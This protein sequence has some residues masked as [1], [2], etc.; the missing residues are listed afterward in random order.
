LIHR[1][2]HRGGG[3]GRVNTS[4]NTYHSLYKGLIH[5]DDGID[6]SG[7]DGYHSLYKGLIQRIRLTYPAGFLSSTIPYIRDWY[8]RDLHTIL[9]LETTIPYIRDWY[10]K[11]IIRNTLLYFQLPFPI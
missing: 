5:D 3:S 9:V 2:H 4:V 1:R 6:D 7:L 8:L 10:K 11:T